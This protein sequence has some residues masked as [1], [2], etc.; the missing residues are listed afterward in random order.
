ARRVRRV[1]G[2]G[3]ADRVPRRAR[4][5]P[6]ALVLP[7]RTAVGAVHALEGPGDPEPPRAH[8]RERGPRIRAGGLKN[9]RPFDRL[10]DAGQS[11]LMT[12]WTTPSESR[13]TRSTSS[14]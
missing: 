3:G 6:R 2:R 4:G 7:G 10:R 12:D 9:P 14:V 11:A 13:L 1:Q 8:R 5:S